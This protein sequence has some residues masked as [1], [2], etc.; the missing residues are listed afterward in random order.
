MECAN[1]T[2]DEYSVAWG[3]EGKAH[4]TEISQVRGGGLDGWNCIRLVGQ[5]GQTDCFLHLLTP[6]FVKHSE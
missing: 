4:M 3:K 6:N 5:E 1:G 2:K